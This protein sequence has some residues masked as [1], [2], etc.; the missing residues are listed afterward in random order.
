MAGVMKL[1]DAGVLQ[2]LRRKLNS[3]G[4]HGENELR[5]LL[6]KVRLGEAYHGAKTAPE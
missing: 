6:D 5:C 3:L 1:A 4:F 2:P